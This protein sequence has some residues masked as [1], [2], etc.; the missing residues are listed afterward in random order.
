MWIELGAGEDEKVVVN[1]DQ[2][3]TSIQPTVT[4]TRR[5]STNS[6]G[7]KRDGIYAAYANGVVK[8][9]KT[10][11]EWKVGPDKNTNWN[12]ARSWVQ[13][14]NLDGGGWRMPTMDELANLYNDGARKFNRTSL[15]KTTGWWV[16]SGETNGSLHAWGFNFTATGSRRWGL[17]AYSIST[18]AFAARHLDSGKAHAASDIKQPALTKIIS[19]ETVSQYLPGNWKMVANV[20]YQFTLEIRLAGGN[21]AGRMICT[22]F[23][24]PVD[25]ISGVITPN[26]EIEF[27]RTRPGQWVQKYSGNLIADLLLDIWS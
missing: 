24:E 19:H 11:L 16:W 10:G 14:L 12:E 8:D 9:T 4:Y 17:R 20:K 6:N 25:K 23:R 3:R 7:I 5:P 22:N 1:L 27:N 2:L 21:I 26:G 18:R 13:S 15:L